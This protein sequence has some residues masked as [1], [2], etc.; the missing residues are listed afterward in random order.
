[1][2]KIRFDEQMIIK[3]EELD[4]VTKASPKYV[5]FAPTFKEQSLKKYQEGY[6]GWDIFLEAGFP[7]DLLNSE[8]IK[9]ALNRWKRTVREKGTDELSGPKKS[10]PKKS[11]Q[12]E[13]MTKDEKIEHLE[14]ENAFFVALRAR[15]QPKKDLR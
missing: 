10:R 9:S 6:S 12:Y 7:E 11:K 3:L 8:F 14:A 13:D 1:M 4:A 5:V 15:Q 2:A